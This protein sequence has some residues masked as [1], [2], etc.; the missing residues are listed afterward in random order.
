MVSNKYRSQ[1]HANMY[2]H[3]VESGKGH[4]FHINLVYSLSI[5]RMTNKTWPKF[6]VYWYIDWKP[7]PLSIC[8]VEYHG[9][10]AFEKIENPG[11]EM[12]ANW[13][14]LRHVKNK[15]F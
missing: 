13:T 15:D 9:L 10:A 4:S 7:T 2:G 11:S 5:V 6:Q 1:P 12:D 3:S 8:S 14:K